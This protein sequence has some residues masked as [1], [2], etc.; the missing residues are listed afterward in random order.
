MAIRRRTDAVFL[1]V[2]FD[3]GYEPIFVGLLAALV[4][5]GK[6]PTTVLDV[7]GPGAPRLERLVELI[8]S[9]AF[10]VH[11]LSRVSC[12]G[13]GRAATPRFNMPFELGLAVAIAG[14][15]RRLRHGF[16]VLEERRYR[17]QRTLSDMNGYDP[18]IHGG[19]QAGAIRSMFQ[20]FASTGHGSVGAARRL[21]RNLA[22]LAKELKKEH[23][24]RL[25]FKRLVIHDMV[26]A[27]TEIGAA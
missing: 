16:V 21:A 24:S 9:C 17:L 2:P 18:I 26:E 15:P 6:R 13:A 14:G 25:L 3:A 7:E 20:V 22:T 27:A 1:N 8:R 23:G 11:D 19:S 12:S 10:S 5:L 4:I